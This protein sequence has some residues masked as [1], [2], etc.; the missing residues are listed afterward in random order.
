[1]FQGRG[2]DKGRIRELNNGGSLCARDRRAGSVSSS[3]KNLGQ[4]A[5][6]SYGQ[7]Q[8]AIPVLNPFLL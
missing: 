6:V 4:Q 2:M 5:S 1:M 3:W 7:R 8:G